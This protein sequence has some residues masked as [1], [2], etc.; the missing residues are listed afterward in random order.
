MIDAETAI[1]FISENS[2]VTPEVLTHAARHYTT[3]IVLCL[4]SE[5]VHHPGTLLRYCLNVEDAANSIKKEISKKTKSSNLSETENVFDWFFGY[6]R[7][8]S[9]FQIFQNSQ[10]CSLLEFLKNTEISSDFQVD[11][12]SVSS[13]LSIDSPFSRVSRLVE[14][15]EWLRSSSLGDSPFTKKLKLE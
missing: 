9:I 13:G 2:R 6:S 8:L 12:L 11:H 15:S 3:V 14:S 5:L 7:N 4:T 1:Y 10:S